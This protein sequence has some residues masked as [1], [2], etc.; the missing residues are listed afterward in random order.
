MRGTSA[1]PGL[2]PPQS[3]AVKE[4]VLEAGVAMLLRSETLKM[5]T[6]PPAQTFLQCLCNKVS[7]RVEGV[8]MGGA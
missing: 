6:I 5:T 7:R 2:C 8:G 1:S 3:L 4:P